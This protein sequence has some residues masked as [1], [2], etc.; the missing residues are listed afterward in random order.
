MKTLKSKVTKGTWLDGPGVA[1]VYSLDK[2]RN[3]LRVLVMELEG[4]PTVASL[5]EGDG[6]THNFKVHAAGML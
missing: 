6:R 2:R 1:T 5:I 3:G 4:Q